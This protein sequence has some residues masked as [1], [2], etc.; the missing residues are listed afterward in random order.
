[1]SKALYSLAILSTLLLV[2][3]CKKDFE[4]NKVPVAD[5]GQSKQLRYL[6]QQWF[7]VLAPTPMVKWWLI[8]GARFPDPPILLL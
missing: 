3:S 7:Q 5:A 8:C 6:I 4:E 2:V 1:M